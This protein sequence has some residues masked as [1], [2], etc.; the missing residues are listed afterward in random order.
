MAGSHVNF[1]IHRFLFGFI[2]WPA[3]HSVGNNKGWPEGELQSIFAC[4]D[5]QSAIIIRFLFFFLMAVTN[6]L[7]KGILHANIK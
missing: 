5:N 6:W 7:S 3:Q 4:L 2:L 1:Q